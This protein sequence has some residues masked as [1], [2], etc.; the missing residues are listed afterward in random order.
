VIHITDTT[1]FD[2]NEVEERVVRVAGTTAI[3]L[4][5]DIGRSSL[6]TGVKRRLITIGRRFVTA[7][8]VLRVVGPSEESLTVSRDVALG[9]LLRLLMRA[10]VAPPERRQGAVTRVPGAS[11]SHW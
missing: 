2:E 11:S 1:A 9:Q 10:S 3:E 5:F 6:P 8:G 4:R 7:G